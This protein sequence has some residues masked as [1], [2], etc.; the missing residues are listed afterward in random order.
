MTLNQAAFLLFAVQ[1][2]A[3]PSSMIYM[4][5]HNTELNVIDRI[6]IQAEFVILCVALAVS[7][8]S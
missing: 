8:A 5:N 4:I 7:I 6:N 3:F 1:L 2:F